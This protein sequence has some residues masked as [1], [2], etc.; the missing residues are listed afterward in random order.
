MHELFRGNDRAHGTYRDEEFDAEKGKQEI[1]KSARTVRRPPTPDL[2][3]QHLMGEYHLGIITITDEDTV[4]WGAIDIDDY[5]VEHTDLVDMLSEMAVP[6]LVCKTKS[7]GA[8]VYVFFTEQLQAGEV[9]RRLRELSVSLGHGGCEVYPKQV[10][11][12][13]ENE[14]LGNWINMPY[15]GIG[16]GQSRCHAM[17]PDGRGMS[18]EQFLT[19]AEQSRM[20]AEDFRRLQFTRKSE[21]FGDSPPCIESLTKRKLLKGEQNSALFNYAV[22]ARRKYPDSWREKIHEWGTLYCD[23][24]HESVRISSMIGSLEKTDYQYKCHDVPCASHCNQPL[25]RTRRFGIGQGGG[26]ISIES[27]SIL[28][29]EPPMFYVLLK[30]GGTVECDSVSLLNPRAFTTLV[31]EQMKIVLPTLKL[32]AWLP[33]IQLAVAQATLIESPPEVGT[34]GQLHELI[35]RFCTDRH[36]GERVEDLL[37]HKPWRSDEDDMVW[38]RLRDLT[39]FLERNKFSKLRISQITDRIRRMGGRHHFFNLSGKGVNVWGIPASGLA[40]IQGALPTPVLEEG[41]V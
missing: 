40:W 28:D 31:L 8:H 36:A 14:G 2:W 39:E 5:S 24:P 4:W 16:T 10:R 33:Q 34:T 11:V 1:K 13:T 20:S 15:F 26:D 22:L 18:L 17:K 9:L 7:G 29:T 19:T 37:T 27:I 23:P 38:F 6:G 35:E 3:R 41:P 32:E 21:T 12:A 25:C 30:T